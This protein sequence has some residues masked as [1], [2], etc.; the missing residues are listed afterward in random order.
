MSEKKHKTIDDYASSTREVNT[1]PWPGTDK[2]VGIMHLAV[3]ELQDAHFEAREWFKKK[4]R[5]VDLA[6][7][8]ELEREEV[9]QQ[10]YRMLIDPDAKNADYRIFRSVSEARERLTAYEINN[11]CAQYQKLYPDEVDDGNID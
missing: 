3:G 6:S 1:V 11:L 4:S 8:V 5:E 7:M 2:L 9:V 10:C